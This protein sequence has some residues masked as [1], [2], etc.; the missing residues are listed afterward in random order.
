LRIAK[1]N[2]V[3]GTQDSST[4]TNASELIHSMVIN[5]VR[6]RGD[7]HLRAA[8]TPGA[9][10]KNAD[11]HEPPGEVINDHEDRAAARPRRRRLPRPA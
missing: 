6:K 3:T 1:V 11:R 4:R 7:G 9:A 5:N 2:L 8:Q 10:L